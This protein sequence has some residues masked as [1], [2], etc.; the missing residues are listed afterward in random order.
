MIKKSVHYNF[1]HFLEYMM[2][3]PVLVM[4]QIC[5]GIQSISFITFCSFLAVDGKIKC[6]I[7]NPEWDIFRCL[8]YCSMYSTWREGFRSEFGPEVG[9]FGKFHSTKTSVE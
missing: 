3:L 2:K 4:Y 5:V 1:C 8:R 9:L 6:N 7:Q